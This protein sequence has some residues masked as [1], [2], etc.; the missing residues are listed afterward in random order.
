MKKIKLLTITLL[1]T[2]LLFT[3]C[4]QKGDSSS[5]SLSVDGSP[6][7]LSEAQDLVGKWKLNTEN[8]QIKGSCTIMN[9]TTPIDDSD[10]MYSEFAPTMYPNNDG[11]VIEFSDSSEAEEFIQWFI[12]NSSMNLQDFLSLIQNMPSEVPLPDFSEIYKEYS[13]KYKLYLNEE[14]NKL[15]ILIEMKCTYD[16]DKLLIGSLG[17]LTNITSNS[18]LRVEGPIFG[19]VTVQFQEVLPYTKLLNSM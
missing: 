1:I 2:G 11:D 3:S 9:Q 5:G 13:C 18:S 10:E 19:D 14:K 12:D 4:G 15:S 8:I 6:I 17:G 16:M 7:S